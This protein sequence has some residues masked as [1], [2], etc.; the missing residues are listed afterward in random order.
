MRRFSVSFWYSVVSETS[1]EESLYGVAF[2]L[3]TSPYFEIVADSKYPEGPLRDCRRFVPVVISLLTR[4]QSR[5]VKKLGEH[6]D[7]VM[8]RGGVS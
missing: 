3:D 7:E 8:N 5:T 4:G 2:N 1:T 6:I